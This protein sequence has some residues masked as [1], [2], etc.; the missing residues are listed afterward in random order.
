MTAAIPPVAKPAHI[1]DS[2]VVEFDIYLDQE[3]L[4]DPHQKVEKMLREYPPVFWTPHNFG[5]WVVLSHDAV[6]SASQNTQRFSSEIMTSEMMSVLESMQPPGSGRLIQTI[7][8]NVDPPAHTKLRSPLLKPFSPKAVAER[9]LEITQLAEQLIAAVVDKGQ[10]EFISAIAEPLPVTIFMKMMGLPLERLSEFREIVHKF[11]APGMNDPMEVFARQR[12][13]ANAMAEVIQARRFKPEDDLISLLWSA[14]IDGQPMTLELMEDYCT[15]LFIA[16]LDTVINGI[17]YG[18]K[19]LAG[20]QPLQC[21]LR[22]QP[23][24]IPDAVE[25]LLRRYTFTIPMRRVTE[26]CELGGQQLQAGDLLCLYL[27]AADLDP[28]AFNNPAEFQLKRKESGHIA[29][30]VGPHRCLGSH[31]ARLEL[32]LVYQAVL[33][34]LPSFALDPNQPVTYRGGNILAIESLPLVWQSP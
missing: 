23:E 16:G 29:F 3:L 19:H 30:G 15:L 17:G 11:L 24:L 6:F 25:E 34:Q 9:K 32:T 13:V 33:Q 31:L 8:I 1:P 22:A 18:I 27:P 10:C 5:H 14:T 12:M 4:H 7:P 26:A 28:K 2:A 20:N 21:Q